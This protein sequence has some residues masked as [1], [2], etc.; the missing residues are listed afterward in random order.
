LWFFLFTP[1]PGRFEYMPA[2]PY[3]YQLDVNRKQVLLTSLP[4]LDITSPGSGELVS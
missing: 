3:T 4:F 2:Y 1:A